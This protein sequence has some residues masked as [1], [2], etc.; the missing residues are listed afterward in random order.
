MRCSNIAQVLFL[1]ICSSLLIQIN[2]GRTVLDHLIHNH[3]APLSWSVRLRIGLECAQAMEYLH[4]NRMVYRFM[5]ASNVILTDSD[6][7]VCFLSSFLIIIRH[8]SVQIDRLR[9]D[10]AQKRR[11][12]ASAL[13]GPGSAQ[14][15]SFHASI[16]C[17][18]LWNI[19]DG[20]VHDGQ[21]TVFRWVFLY[22]S[23]KFNYLFRSS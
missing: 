6:F 21:E 2:S 10:S 8:F 23:N 14:T 17:M 16:G 15:L 9:T 18:G 11:C 3:I 1:Y 19:L 12:I 5:C 22:F 13:D 4:Q 7:S 20:I